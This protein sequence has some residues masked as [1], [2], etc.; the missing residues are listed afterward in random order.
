MSFNEDPTQGA[1]MGADEDPAG[2]GIE[3]EGADE[4]PTQTAQ[5]GGTAADDPTQ[6]LELGSEG[7]EDPSAS[8]GG[9]GDDPSARSA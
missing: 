6:G 9:A 5:V 3:G 1:G 7:S 8:G 2:A 4:D